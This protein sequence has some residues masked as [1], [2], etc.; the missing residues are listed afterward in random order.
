MSVLESLMLANS[1]TQGAF[2][3]D[4][5]EFFT[6]VTSKGYR[7]GSDGS[8]VLTLPELLGAGPGGIGGNYAEG[9]D[10]QTVLKE[11]IQENGAKMLMQ[12]VAIPIGFR[13]LSRLLKKPRSQAN[14]L[15]RQT[16]MAVKV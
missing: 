1:V 10:L 8:R 16:G 4:L 12:L 7:P 3:T 9:L 2:N 5:K 15:L 6:G 13:V 14:R 11:N